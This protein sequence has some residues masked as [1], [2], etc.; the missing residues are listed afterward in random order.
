MGSAPGERLAEDSPRKVAVDDDEMRGSGG[1]LLHPVERGAVQ[2]AQ[3]RRALREEQVREVA[4]EEDLRNRA[5]FR[6]L[7]VGAEA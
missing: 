5:P 7:Q 3:Q 6:M 4:V 1:R 2:L